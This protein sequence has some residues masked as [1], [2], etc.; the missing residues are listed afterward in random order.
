MARMLKCDCG[1]PWSK[2]VYTVQRSHG[3]RWTYYR[4]PVCLREWTVQE[5]VDDLDDPVTSDEVLEVHRLAE[6]GNL[7]ELF[8][9]PGHLA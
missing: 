9:A 4:C 3:H 1:V 5:D 6:A 8:T 2:C 7:A